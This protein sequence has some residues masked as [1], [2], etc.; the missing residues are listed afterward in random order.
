MRNATR[1]RNERAL[2]LTIGDPVVLRGEVLSGPNLRG[3]VRVRLQGRDGFRDVRVLVSGG[4]LHPVRKSW[5]RRL[6]DRFL[7]WLFD[8]R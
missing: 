3:E 7:L 8:A 1:A 4:L 2:K 6:Q 5:L